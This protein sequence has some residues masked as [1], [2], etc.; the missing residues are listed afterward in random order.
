MKNSKSLTE[1]ML[2]GLMMAAVV[3][4]AVPFPEL[5]WAQAGLGASATAIVTNELNPTTPLLAAVL[6]IGGGALIGAGALK[7]KQHSENP[8]QTPMSHGLGRI[9]AGAALMAIPYFADVAVN[10]MHLGAAATPF[11]AFS[12]L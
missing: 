5:A 11:A 9:G 12:A 6:Y 4:A 10:T 2:K 1:S 8:T 7:L 3:A